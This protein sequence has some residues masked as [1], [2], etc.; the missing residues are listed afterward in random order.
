MVVEDAR[1]VRILVGQVVCADVATRG[2]SRLN[3]WI[4][5]VNVVVDRVLN[6]SEAE[7]SVEDGAAVLFVPLAKAWVL[8][9]LGQDLVERWHRMVGR[10][11]LELFLD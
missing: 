11:V 10:E 1:F 6:P 9:E 5:T 8:V 4:S 3:C 2:P 7:A